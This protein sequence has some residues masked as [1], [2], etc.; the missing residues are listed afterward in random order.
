M[1]PNLVQRLKQRLHQY[2][3]GPALALGLCGALAA[4]TCGLTAK[5]TK[6]LPNSN[7]QLMPFVIPAYFRPKPVRYRL[8]REDDR[9]RVYVSNDFLISHKLFVDDGND[10][11]LDRVATLL[12]VRGAAGYYDEPV[13]ERYRSL[14]RRILDYESGR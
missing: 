12:P 10:G 3:D 7:E 4:G 9:T 11:T 6:V 1:T 5:P 2:I 14:Y 13:S 8:E